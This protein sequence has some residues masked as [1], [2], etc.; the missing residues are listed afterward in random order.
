MYETHFS[1]DDDD[2]RWKHHSV[3]RNWVGPV[4]AIVLVF[5]FAAASA[6]WMSR[7]AAED[8]T[9]SPF[10]RTTADN[11]TP[12]DA[13]LGGPAPANDVRNAQGIADANNRTI[14]G[15]VTQLD[16]AQNTMTLDNGEVYALAG[17]QPI[18]VTPGTRVTI[19]YN[20][21]GDRNI[22]T[23]VQ[24]VTPEDAAGAMNR[25]GPL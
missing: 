24:A 9:G 21:Q 20:A 18:D 7:L 5:G 8:G 14:T 13:I 3:R 4:V 1:D 6:I 16:A 17:N 15:T 25:G 23:R 22:A 2:R 19:T 11:A 10:N 12:Q